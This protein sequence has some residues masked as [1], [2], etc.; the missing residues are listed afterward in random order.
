M[1]NKGMFQ[2]R[3]RD[4]PLE[5]RFTETWEKWNEKY[6]GS[7]GILSCLLSEDNRGRHVTDKERVIAATIIQWLG[8]PVGQEFLKE[9]MGKKG[10]RA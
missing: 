2:N 1:K 9:V 7:L 3:L 4:N 8:S 6:V 10:G 5:Q